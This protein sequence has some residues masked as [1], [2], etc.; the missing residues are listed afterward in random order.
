V[1]ELIEKASLENC[2]ILLPLGNLAPDTI[3]DK[4]SSRAHIIRV[5]VYYT[6]KPALVNREPI[7]RI[8]AD[9]Y[10]LILFTSPS[11]VKN[12]AEVMGPALM[13][14]ELRI[15]SIG[16]VTTR[17]VESYGSVCL[18]TAKKPTYEDLALE[19]LNYYKLKV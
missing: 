11:G 2:H 15:A 5:N 7:E 1:N 8:E 4:L 12:F 6:R 9:R 18:V 10:D 14:P 17:A 3:Q 13:T 19:I 16:E